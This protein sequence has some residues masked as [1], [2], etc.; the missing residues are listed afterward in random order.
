MRRKQA[1][2]PLFKSLLTFDPALA[3]GRSSSR[4]RSSRA[5]SIR[6]FRRKRPTGSRS[7][8]ARARRR[9]RRS[10]CTS[11]A[12]IT[13]LS[14]R[15]GQAS[16]YAQL[17]PQSAEMAEAIAEWMKKPADREAERNFDRN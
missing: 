6:T 2:T 5:I 10:A 17:R 7:W 3:L 8:R 16:D 1:E 14:R 13:R 9:R 15:R 12:S 11:R 4:F